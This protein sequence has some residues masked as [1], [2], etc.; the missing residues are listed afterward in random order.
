M[1]DTILYRSRVGLYSQPPPR[2]LKTCHK[3]TIFT[4][5]WDNRIW[6]I[7]STLIIMTT[8]TNQQQQQQ[9][10]S[11]SMTKEQC[12]SKDG[13]RSPKF[14]LTGQGISP[15]NSGLSVNPN[16]NRTLTFW[17]EG[18]DISRVFTEKNCSEVVYTVKVKHKINNKATKA[19][20][21]NINTTIKALHWNIGN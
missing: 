13:N 20:N 10:Q 9:L 11:I 8:L 21:G 12:A 18:W 16:G 5:H 2:K 1:I 14:P 15:N 6:L 7:F 4:L 19:Y 3:T 17:Q